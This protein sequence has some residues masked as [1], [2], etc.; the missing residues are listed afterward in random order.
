MPLA[1]AL[2]ENLTEVCVK[3]APGAQVVIHGSEARFRCCTSTLQPDWSE[4]I[5]ALPS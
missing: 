2:D 4:P 5:Q 1:V 3:R